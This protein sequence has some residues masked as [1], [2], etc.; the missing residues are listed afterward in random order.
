[1][2]GNS[3]I[4]TTV[5][6]TLASAGVGWVQLVPAGEVSAG[7]ACPGGLV[8]ADEGSRFAVA[9][10]AGDASRNRPA[11]AAAR[12]RPVGGPTWWC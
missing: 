10:G 4:T 8:P 3:R 9:G 12:Y 2:H 11:C 5:A 7:E 6:S 1:M